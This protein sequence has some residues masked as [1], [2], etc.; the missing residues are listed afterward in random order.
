MYARL[1]FTLLELLIV[2]AIIGALSSIVF[3]TLNSARTNAVASK[4]ASELREIDRAWRSWQIETGSDWRNENDYN[5][6]ADAYGPGDSNRDC[7][8]EV[9]MSDTE[10]YADTE[11]TPGWNGP[12]LQA[13]MTGPFGLPYAY[14]FDDDSYPGDSA[15]GLNIFL[16]WCN[17]VYQAKYLELAPEIDNIF[18]SGDGASS[19]R[20]RWSTDATGEMIFMIDEN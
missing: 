19:G 8:D 4:T 18:D 9:P 10:L 11:S 13:D 2:V 14:D 20:V 12:Y 3:A 16:P 15:G 7:S 6:A 17:E 5:N 1:G